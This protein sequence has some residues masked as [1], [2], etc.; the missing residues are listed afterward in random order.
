[1]VD[2][3]KPHTFVIMKESI[4][5]II[6]KIKDIAA[7]SNVVSVP[8]E[9]KE[10]HRPDNALSRSIRNEKEA[11]QFRAQLKAAIELGESQ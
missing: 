6:N 8:K 10:Q 5:H 4:Q 3:I 2:I 11:A 7:T 1:M 9:S